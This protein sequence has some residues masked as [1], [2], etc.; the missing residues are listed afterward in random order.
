SSSKLVKAA[1]KHPTKRY[2]L[3]KFYRENFQGC[4][5]VYLS[6][7]FSLLLCFSVTACLDYHKFFALST[8]FLNYFLL[9]VKLCCFSQQRI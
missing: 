6:R 7:F 3:E 5:V 9:P 2:A 1:S 8:T 4:I